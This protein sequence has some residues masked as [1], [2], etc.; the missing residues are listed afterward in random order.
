MLA[1][2]YFLTAVVIGIA[3]F[4]SAFTVRRKF[5]A[6]LPEFRHEKFEESK[7]GA[8]GVNLLR[9]ERSFSERLGNIRFITSIYHQI[10]KRY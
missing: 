5:P 4:L 10:I 7:S 8:T 9:D 3:A 1:I 2:G 6:K